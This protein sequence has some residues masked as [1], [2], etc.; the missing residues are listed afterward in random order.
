MSYRRLFL[1][2]ASASELLTLGC[3]PAFG[4]VL[5]GIS[6]ILFEGAN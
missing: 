4:N 6:T 1:L 2:Q 5:A 3:I